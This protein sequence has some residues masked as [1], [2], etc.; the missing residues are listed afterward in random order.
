MLNISN[1]KIVEIEGIYHLKN[2]AFLDISNNLIEK[3][4]SDDLP[5][6]LIIVRMS[7]NPVKPEVYRK[8]LVMALND[9]TELDK[10]K[11]VAAERLWYHGLLP[12][13][14]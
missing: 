6:N 9:L 14:L 5:E 7:K 11:V 10:I 3:C 12:K 4:D 2:L 13:A 8:K 1:N